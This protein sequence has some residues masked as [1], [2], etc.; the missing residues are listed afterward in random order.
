LSIFN[1]DLNLTDNFYS[2]KLPF[3]PE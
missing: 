1:S 2:F 3:I